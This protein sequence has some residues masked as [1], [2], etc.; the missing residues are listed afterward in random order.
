MEAERRRRAGLSQPTRCGLLC[1]IIHHYYV[2]VTSDQRMDPHWDP[3][4]DATWDA[5]FA[6][7][8][9]SKLT[10]YEGDEPPLVNNNEAGAGYGRVVGLSRA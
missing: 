3:D 7:Q 6:N 5:F 10:R 1:A 4:N 2:T 8:Q 9:E